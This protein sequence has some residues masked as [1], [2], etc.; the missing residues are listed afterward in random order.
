MVQGLAE[1][2]GGMLNLRSIPG[3]GTTAEIWLPAATRASLGVSPSGVDGFRVPHKQDQT[4]L[5]V[6]VVD[7]DPLVLS[8]TAAMLEDLGHI[9][10]AA[11]SGEQALAALRASGFD[12]LLTD[13]A[14][15]RMTGAQL[16]RETSSV[17][18]QMKVVL[19]SGFAELPPDTGHILRLRKPYSQADL[20]EVLEATRLARHSRARSEAPAVSSRLR[21]ARTNRE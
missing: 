6:L 21:H 19:A 13:H 1:Q 2:S 7:D 9:I 15:P 12:V 14:M 20:A 3:V 8:N 4:P 16:I 18:P 10:V 11:D 17:Y 5:K